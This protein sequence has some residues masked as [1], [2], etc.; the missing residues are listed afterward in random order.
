LSNSTEY[1]RGVGYFTF[2][3][4]YWLHI[5]NGDEL[6][7]RFNLYIQK[8]GNLTVLEKDINQYIKNKA[9]KDYQHSVLKLPK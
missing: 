2:G 5:Y 1:K 8:I 7:E 9:T 3:L 4:L 6:D